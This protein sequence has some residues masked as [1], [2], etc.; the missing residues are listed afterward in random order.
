[1]NRDNTPWQPAPAADIDW[2]DSGVPR[3]KAFGDVYFSKED[4]L[5]ESRHV[6]LQGNLLPDR[7]QRQATGGTFYIAETGFG[8]GLNFLMTWQAWLALP[9][10][11]QPLHYLSFERYPLRAQDIRRALEHWPELAPLVDELLRNYP[12]LLPGQHRLVLAAG[13]LTLDLWWEDVSHALPEL[14]A[15]DGKRIDAWYLDGFAPARNQAMWTADISNSAIAG[16]TSQHGTFSTFTAAGHVRRGLTAAG[17]QVS[18]VAGFGRKR[19]RLQGVRSAELPDR[20]NTCLNTPWHSSDQVSERPANAIVI[21]AGLAG[22]TTAAALARRG[23][24]VTLLESRQLASGGSG[25]EQG[26]LYTRLS[27]KHS[28]LTDFAL[29]SFRF[30]ANTYREAFASG[31]LIADQDGALC[32]SFHLGASERDLHYLQDALREV[33]ELAAVLSEQQA[34]DI[35]GVTQM[36]PGLWF[37]DSGWLRPISICSALTNHAAIE[38]IE[39]CGDIKLTRQ[40]GLWQA[41][42]RA[43]TLAQSPCAIIATGTETRSF[44]PLEWLPLQSIRGQT[45]Q[46]PESADTHAL[47]AALCHEGYIA[48][49]RDGFHC[50]GA[51]FN[52]NDE[53]NALRDEDHRVNLQRLA[54]AVPG[55]RAELELLPPDQLQGRVGFR[56]ASPDYLPLVGPVPDRSAFLQV[57][58]GLRKN[59]KQVI[60]RRGP[61]LPG[62][63]LTTGHGSRGLSSTPLAAEILASQ[64]TGEPLPLSRE[65]CRAL[66]PARFLI[67]DLVRNRI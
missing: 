46:L 37:P 19:E 53:A 32:G 58:G 10:P 33:P 52:L 14:A 63:Y 4:G 67:R 54:A 3:S 59:A 7:W 41:S 45:T 66:S 27:R 11:R 31:N 56:C 49:A 5:A 16:M 34:R 64:I 20:V 50:I 62:L 1:M 2:S 35:L 6:F 55:W 48:P 61:C 36:G 40:N 28:A 57:F 25:N 13:K 12:G 9:E 18:K 24:R 29:Q 43:G 44:A 60:P 8:T 30:A 21:G 26:I 51:T 39:N 65:L 22:C 42:N 17:F 23:I 38:L 47:K 15:Q